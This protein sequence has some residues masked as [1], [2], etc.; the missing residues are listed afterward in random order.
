MTLFCS[1]NYAPV[2]GSDGET[3][4]NECTLQRANC[5]KLPGTRKVTKD[6][7]GE[8][9]A[10]GISCTLEFLLLNI[11]IISFICIP[12]SK[13]GED[14]PTSCPYN[15]APICGSD[16]ETYSNEC[17]LRDANC[18]RITSNLEIVHQGECEAQLS[19]LFSCIN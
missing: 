12:T 4:T 8:C 9:L 2:C 19:K 1:S 7:E 5:Y 10:P 16:G 3:Y 15:F 13:K 17:A 6:H 11:S 14:C 18:G